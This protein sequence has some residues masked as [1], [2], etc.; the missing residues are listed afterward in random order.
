[1]TG[2]KKRDPDVV[3][4]AQL[5]QTLWDCREYITVM[6]ETALGALSVSFPL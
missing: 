4:L 2:L 5:S 6:A 1:M 3:P